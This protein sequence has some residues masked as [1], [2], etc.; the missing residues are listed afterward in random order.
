MQSC[1][2]RCA[3]RLASVEEFSRRLRFSSTAWDMAFGYGLCLDSSDGMRDLVNDEILK[4]RYRCII[5]ARVRQQLQLAGHR[6]LNT[7]A[8]GF[9]L[10]NGLCAVQNPNSAMSK[11]TTAFPG[12]RHSSVLCNERVIKCNL[13]YCVSTS[14]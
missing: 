7:Y 9:T 4:S 14:D 8:T 10:K 6:L 13:H 1:C 5:G 2:R 11:K 3:G 12:A